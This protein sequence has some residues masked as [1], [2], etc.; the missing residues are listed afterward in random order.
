V[1]PADQPWPLHDVAGSRAIEQRAAAGLPAGALM[2]RA[3]HGVARLAR[4]L[5]PEARRIWVAAGPGG[6]GGDGLHAAAELQQAGVQVVASLLAPPDRLPPDAAEGLQRARDAGVSV[7]DA[8][9]SVEGRADRFGL[10]IDALLG[11]GSARAPTGPIAQAI[12]AIRRAAAP[13]LAVDLPSGL[14]PVTGAPLGADVV[15][16]RATLALLTLKPGLFTAA[17]RDHAGEIWFDALDLAAAAEPPAA[18]LTCAADLAQARAA[19]RH[20]QHK[21]SFGDT[22]VVGGAPGMIGAARLAAH[23]ALAAGAGRTIVSLFDEHARH[24]DATRPEWLWCVAAWQPGRADL[25]HS[26]VVCGC[27]GGDAVRAALPALLARSARLVLDADALNAVAA[28]PTLRMQLRARA[29]RGRPTILTPHPLE[30][31]RLLGAGTTAVQGDR[32]AAAR[33]LAEDLGCVVVLK[34]SGSVLAAPGQVSRLNATGSAAL[35]TGGTGDVLAGWIGGQWSQAPP[36]PTSAVDSGPALEAALQVASGS[37]WLHG[38]AGEQL[39]G[40]VA[41]GL[42]LV[43]AMHRLAR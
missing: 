35:A 11:L 37:V 8:V 43:E 36:S 3:A 32:L 10:V 28:D 24:E 41:R 5:A 12:G 39:P 30:A 19:R 6:N 15:E 25:E 4:A 9:P 33:Q 14:H 34:G 17:G 27:G 31:A 7:T 29:A 42:D 13:C 40:P 22:L 16:A 38:L 26:T 21:G 1:L 18:R 23:A 20:A 2:R